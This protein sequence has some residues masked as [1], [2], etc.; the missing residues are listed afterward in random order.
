MNTFVVDDMSVTVPQE[1]SDLASFRRWLHA[2]EFPEQ[3]RISYFQGKVHVDMSKEQI[4]SHNQVKNEIAYT[5]TGLAKRKKDGRC[6]PDGIFVAHLTADLSCQPDGVFVSRSSLDAGRVRLIEG[7]HEGFVEIEGS[8]DMVIEVVSRSSVLKDTETL[9]DL[10]W[11]AGIEE[12]WLVD[13]RDAKP[14]LA[15]Y[16]AHA[17]GFVAAKKLAGWTRSRVFGE[18]FQLLATKDD[19][20]DPAFSL[21]IDV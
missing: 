18:A 9:L 15:I 11:Q 4:F 19:R 12:Y 17:K 6:F 2:E 3:G 5:L 13:A 16:S 8:P 21:V 7:V 14:R 1:V 10:Y 20:G